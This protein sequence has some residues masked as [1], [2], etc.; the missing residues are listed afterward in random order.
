M[1]VLTSLHEPSSLRM[2][3]QHTMP[4]GCLCT[5]GGGDRWRQSSDRLTPP[6]FAQILRIKFSRSKLDLVPRFSRFLDKSILQFLHQSC[7]LPC[8]RDIKSAAAPAIVTSSFEIFS[9]FTISS[10]SA[11]WLLPSHSPP[12]RL[13]PARY[14]SLLFR[15]YTPTQ[16]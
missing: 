12:P 9:A 14:V 4:A 13:P 11:P 3:P 2:Y 1:Q 10:N 6:D 15:A 7:S 8:L 5:N 16:T